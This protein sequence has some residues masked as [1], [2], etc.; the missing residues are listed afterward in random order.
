MVVPCR[1]FVDLPYKLWINNLR[2]SMPW[3]RPIYLIS[4]FK[5]YAADLPCRWT[6]F[7]DICPMPC[8]SAL[9]CTEE[10][11][12]YHQLQT[13]CF[14]RYSPYHMD[15]RTNKVNKKGSFQFCIDRLGFSLTM[16]W[17]LRAYFVVK[18]AL[19]M[20]IFNIQKC[21]Y[22]ILL[23]EYRTRIPF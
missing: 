6:V 13:L 7:K 4:S 5:I 3:T 8:R 21:S 12:T 10:M 20:S 18:I 16:N 9:T 15:Y 22:G 23:K 19:L 17:Q 1:L 14:I 2:L 11:S